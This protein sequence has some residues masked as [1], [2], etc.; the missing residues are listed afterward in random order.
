MPIC[1]CLTA[2]ARIKKM[3]QSDDEVGKLATATPF[4]MCT[5]QLS[6]FL[7]V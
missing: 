2:Q 7:I 5:F 1:K 6:L 3:M 4:L